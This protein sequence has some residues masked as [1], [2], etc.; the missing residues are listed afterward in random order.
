MSEM[1]GNQY[2][3][4]RKYA[5]AELEL[6]PVLMENSDNNST[7][8][9]LIICYTQTGKIDKALNLF[10]ELVTND[11]DFI[12]SA[13]PVLDDCPCP[14]LVSEIEKIEELNTDS[15]DY[16]V[17]FGMIWL[18]CDADKSLYYFKKANAIRSENT[19]IPKIVTKIY[20]YINKSKK[21][22]LSQKDD[23]KKIRN[24]SLMK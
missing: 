20:N 7:K 5:D 24:E 13:D 21:G 14:E 3:M 18:Y 2:F 16:H 19:M 22:S 12:T 23:L 1:L 6:E 9:K 8:R 17:L 11:I 4:A 10:F 15:F